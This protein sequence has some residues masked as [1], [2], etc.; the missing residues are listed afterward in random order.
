MCMTDVIF[1]CGCCRTISRGGTIDEAL[2]AASRTAT[3]HVV[4][5][6]CDAES[7]IPLIETMLHDPQPTQ[8]LR[9]I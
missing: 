8:T 2:V 6:R 4:C 5:E 1:L 7:D 9:L 3:W